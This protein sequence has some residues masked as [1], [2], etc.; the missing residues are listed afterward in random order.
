MAESV[1]KSNSGKAAYLQLYDYFRKLIISGEMPSGSKMPSIRGC[2]E[3]Y[4]LSRTTVESAYVLLEAE[5]CIYAVPQ[6]GF[7][8]SQMENFQTGTAAEKGSAL[9]ADKYNIKYDFTSSA[10]DKESFDF[11]LWQRYIK[12]ALRT[13]ER[14]LDYGDPQGEADLRKALCSYVSRSR[15][16]MCTE[17]RIVIGAGVQ[18]LLQLLCVLNSE[19]GIVE[20]MGQPYPK[21]ETIFKDYGFGIAR[22]ADYDIEAVTKTDGIKM[23]YTCPSHINGT[24]DVLT[25]P[26]RI[27][28]LKYARKSG[29]VVIEDDFDSEFSYAGRPAP[30]LQSLDGGNNVIY[31]GTFS[32]LLLPSIRISFLVLTPELSEKYQKIK[33]LYNQTTSKTEQIALCR[34]ISDG[35]L[36]QR[37][38]KTKKL[39]A[40]KTRR[41]FDELG[42][43]D[44]YGAKAE[45]SRSGFYVSVDLYGINAADLK[46]LALKKGMNINAENSDS[47]G[48][49]RMIFS[50]S[51][52]S[53][54][55]ISDSA[56]CV[57]DLIR[58]L[59]NY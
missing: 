59:Q 14:L 57:G 50:V 41:F 32:R 8:V 46:E 56:K 29:C 15:G 5:G 53:S 4:A 40:E 1:F 28:L 6:S 38:K 44:A 27:E 12:S 51:S 30:S 7:Y 21:G 54:N 10:A 25:V 39:Y 33:Y 11:S 18:N 3:R 22:N 26:K 13:G 24:G 55:E 42:N 58:S 17:N 47:T 37:I 23:I 45:L 16:I 20:F 31:I 43:L 19:R 9:K 34:Y 2:A 36:T 49:A 52:I 48:G 35:H